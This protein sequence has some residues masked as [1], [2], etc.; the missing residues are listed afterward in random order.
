MLTQADIA[1][2]NWLSQ[3]DE[4]HQHSVIIQDGVVFFQTNNAGIAYEQAWINREILLQGGLH[5]SVAIGDQDFDST[6]DLRH[7]KKNR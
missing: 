5:L 6:C 2:A 1:L 3:L 7:F 4:P